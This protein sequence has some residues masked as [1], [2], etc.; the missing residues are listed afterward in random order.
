VTGAAGADGTGFA[1]IDGSVEET[2]SADAGVAPADPTSGDAGVDLG[3]GP[4]LVSPDTCGGAISSVAA[5]TAVPNV[6][7]QPIAVAFVNDT[8]VVVQSRE[9][10]QLELP[11]GPPVVLSTV[12]RSDTG[13]DLFHA[14]AGGF[15]ACASCHAEGTEDGRT[16]DFACIGPRRTQ[17]LQVGLAGTEPFHWD[18]DEKD[19]AQ[20]MTDVFVGR[21]SGPTLA[22][23]QTAAMLHW[24]DAQ[25]RRT[26]TPPTDLAA[27]ARGQALFND[28][29]HVGCATCHNGPSLTNSQTLD[30]GTGGNFQV[31]SLVGIGTR[32]PYMHDG[33][34]ATLR[35]RFGPC[36]GGDRHGMTSTLEP[37]QIDDLLA[38][39]NTL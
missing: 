23:D 1:P 33:C 37:A 9:P 13:H 11:T 35:D 14:N 4:T 3:T 39:L 21:M 34:A 30:V 19:F 10:A 5:S 8:T 16:W 38:Y 32:G 25:P 7:G 18:G 2:G 29:A 24:L 28:T 26:R 6:S 15:V 27:V 20:L 22:S 12:S 36:G 31:P 17:S